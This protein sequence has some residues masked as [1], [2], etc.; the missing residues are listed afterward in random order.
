MGLNTVRRRGANEQGA[1]LVLTLAILMLSGVIFVAM[2]S[3]VTTYLRGGASF[4]S[5]SDRNQVNSDAVEYALAAVRIN[6]TLGRAGATSTWSYGGGSVTCT[7]DTG[8]GVVSGSGRT[9]RLVTCTSGQVT[10][11]IRYFDRGGSGSGVVAEVLSWK[12]TT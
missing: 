12:L 2:M 4:Q 10:A 1:T 3:F 8:S 7:G 5:R 11:Q 6:N 9:D